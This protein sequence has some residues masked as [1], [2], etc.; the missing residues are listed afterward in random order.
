M[1]EYSWHVHRIKALVVVAPRPSLF[2]QPTTIIPESSYPL[3]MEQPSQHAYVLA[4]LTARWKISSGVLDV[5]VVSVVTATATFASL[6]HVGAIKVSPTVF[7]KTFLPYVAVFCDHHVRLR[8]F[9]PASFCIIV[10]QIPASSSSQASLN[11]VYMSMLLD[12]LG[13]VYLLG[14]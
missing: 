7:Y 2:D 4:Q 6:F 12:Q 13:I 14:L 1:F 5:T 8:D 10:G 3:L 9:F 11:D